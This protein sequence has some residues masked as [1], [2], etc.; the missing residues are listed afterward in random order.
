MCGASAAPWPPPTFTWRSASVTSDTPYA[1]LLANAGCE[2]LVIS[3]LLGHADTRVTSRHYA[4]LLDKTISNAVRTL[5]P[6]VNVEVIH[7]KSRR[8]PENRQSGAI[9]HKQCRTRR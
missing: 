9:T 2:L 7:E 4:Q 5:L 3:K 1:A 8:T 6:S